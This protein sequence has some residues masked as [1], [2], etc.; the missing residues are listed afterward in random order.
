M[1]MTIIQWIRIPEST[2]TLKEQQ[3]HLLQKDAG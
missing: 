2:I 1:T 3:M